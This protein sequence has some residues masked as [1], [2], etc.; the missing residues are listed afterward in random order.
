MKIGIIGN[1]FVGSA[2]MH[3][4]ILHVDDIMIYDKDRSRST[5]S[6]EDLVNNSDVIFVCVPTPMFESGE[7][8]LSI[9]NKVVEDLSEYECINGK[10]VY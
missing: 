6:M 7:C 4:F 10:V 1:G 2:I 3:G 5:H 9:V 8:D